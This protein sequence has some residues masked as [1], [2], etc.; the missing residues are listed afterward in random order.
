MKDLRKRALNGVLWTA[1]DRWFGQMI[2]L[3]IFMVLARILGPGPMGSV[4]LA[5]IVIAFFDVFIDQG[6][7]HAIIQRD[8]VADVHLCTAFWINVAFGVCLCLI[9]MVVAAPVA[10]LLKAPDLANVI[11]ALSLLL[12][13]NSLNSVQEAILRRNLDFQK[14]AVRSLIALT[15]GGATGITLA[16]NGFGVWSL[17]GMELARRLIGVATLWTVSD[18]R[19]SMQFSAA[20]YTELFSFGISILG[21]NILDF[22]NRRSDELLIGYFLGH[23][24]LGY[25]SVGY[26]I[27]HVL[28]NLLTGVTSQVTFSTFSRIQA[29]P[30]RMRQAFYTA[31]RYAATAAF[32]LFFA[33]CIMAPD[34]IIALF[35]E[36]WL[37]SAPVMQVLSFVGIL[38]VVYS[39]NTN[40]LLAVGKPSWRLALNTLNAVTNVIVF[41]IAVRFGIVAVAAAH[42]VRG[43]ML[44]PLP[45]HAVKLMI[46]IDLRRYYAQFLKPFAAALVMSASIAALRFAAHGAIPSSILLLICFPAGVLI[47]IVTL[48]AIAPALL[49]EV[50]AMISS[51]A[52]RL[53]VSK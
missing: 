19:P 24:A 28:A 6:L 35:G 1:I 8:T 12:V 14:L 30:Q 36:K 15:V 31:T 5:T 2:A 32:P 45:L 11:R 53:A 39:F 49:A 13:I 34:A 41:L 26:R 29:E 22:V 17:V 47:Y 52:P 33:V 46:E 42:V 51:V 23:V 3:V 20:H 38:R 4:A 16:L 40:V 43:Y 10:V 37:P 21:T 48:K 9:T 18:W 44:S 7:A 50:W 25:Y 27:I